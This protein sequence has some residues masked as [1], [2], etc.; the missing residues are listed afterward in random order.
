M[1]AAGDRA[2]VERLMRLKSDD[3]ALLKKLTQHWLRH[4]FATDIGRRDLFAAKK[5]GGWKDTRSIL[6]Y[7]IDDAEYQRDLIEERGSP[8]SERARNDG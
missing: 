5:Q 2:E 1:F 7:L 4:K 6:G 3:L 8:A